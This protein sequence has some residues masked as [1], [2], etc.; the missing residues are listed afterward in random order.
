MS[1]NIKAPEI[2]ALKKCREAV[3]VVVVDLH[4]V[5]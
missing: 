1:L 3:V 4:S 5:V 2:F